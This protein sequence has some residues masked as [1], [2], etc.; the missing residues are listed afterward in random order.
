MGYGEAITVG[1]TTRGKGVVQ[2]TYS[3]TDGSSITF[4]VSYYNPPSG[5]NFHSVGIPADVEVEYTGVGDTQL[6]RAFEEIKKMINI[7]N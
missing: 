5:V 1:K 2:S 4:T 6:D 3:F 7:N